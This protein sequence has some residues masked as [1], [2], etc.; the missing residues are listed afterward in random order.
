MR[1]RNAVNRK[2][3]DLNES[4]NFKMNLKMSKNWKIVSSAQNIPR[5]YLGIDDVTLQ[6]AKQ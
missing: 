3:Y 1:K 2:K 4:Y 6:Y 5:I